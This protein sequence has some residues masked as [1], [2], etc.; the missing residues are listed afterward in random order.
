MPSGGSAN[1]L[2][3]SDISV[4]TPVMTARIDAVLEA[5]LSP[6]GFERI[7]P[8]RWING[9]HPPIRSIF[10]FQA[11]KGDRYAACW[12]FSLDFVPI[13]RNGRLQWKRTSKSA[14]FDLCIDPINQD[15]R[16]DRSTVSRF[17]FPAKKYDWNRATRTMK[18]SAQLARAD[19]SR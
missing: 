19:Y 16:A 10:E 14:A 15:G 18:N 13:R 5:E 1:T 2:L 8:R 3:E 6:L 9:I 4:P 12:G 11:R 7:G 17:I